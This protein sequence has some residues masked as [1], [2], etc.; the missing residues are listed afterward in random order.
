LVAGLASVLLFRR[1]IPA[2][3]A[4]F[5]AHGLI[6]RLIDRLGDPAFPL[7]WP[8]DLAIPLIFMAGLLRTI[9]RTSGERREPKYLAALTAAV[10]AAP[11]TLLWPIL[12]LIPAMSLR[13][14]IGIIRE[15]RLPE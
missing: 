1:E 5:L 12:G 4:G 15:R 10:S 3:A 2:L 13:V 9:Q 14:A 8:M 11:L 7:S 6:H